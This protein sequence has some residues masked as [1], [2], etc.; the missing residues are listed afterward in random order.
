MQS[1]SH[2]SIGF[3]SRS[4]SAGRAPAPAPAAQPGVPTSPAQVMPAPPRPMLAKGKG[5]SGAT[6]KAL[7][8]YGQGYASDEYQRVYQRLAG[9]LNAGQSAT[10]QTNQAGLGTAGNVA[11]AYSGNAANQINAGYTGAEAINNAIQGGLSNYY[12]WLA[13]Q[14]GHP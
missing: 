10:G 7:L 9:L 14:G 3:G 13:S 2:S 11:N 4:T 1:A 8:K 12:A 5:L 6:A